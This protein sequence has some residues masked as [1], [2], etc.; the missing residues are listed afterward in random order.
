MTTV[1]R[2]VIRMFTCDLD[3]VRWETRIVEGRGLELKVLG[4]GAL[5]RDYTFTDALSLVE[6]QVQYER[7][8]L[9]NG[10]NVFAQRDRRT[11]YDRR[12]RARTTEERRRR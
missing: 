4:P 10:Y 6:Y 12:R 11:G 7:Q 2:P 3:T 8:L 9:S 5:R 1:D